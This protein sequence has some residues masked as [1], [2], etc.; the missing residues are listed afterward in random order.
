MI[1]SRQTING[2]P[3]LV[4]SA[5]RNGVVLT[6]YE[7]RQLPRRLSSTLPWALTSLV[8]AGNLNIYVLPGMVGNF[9]PTI[10]GTSI[11]AATPPALTVTGSAGQ[12]YLK[13]TV[14]AAGA[15][16]D[17]VIESASSVPADTSTA[18]HKLI[19]TWTASG[20]AFTSVTSILNANQTLYLCNGVAIWEA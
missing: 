7:R 15:I 14:D 9:V 4:R 16:T 2:G 3:G 12:V 19:G 11:A 1:P 18:K 10:G 13:A 8:E 20:G 17:L 5:G 6:P